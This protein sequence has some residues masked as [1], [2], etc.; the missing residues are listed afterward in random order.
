MIKYQYAFDN[1]EQIIHVNELSRENL[2][3]EAKFKC[4]SC[5]SELIPRLGK[6][7]LKH[8]AH[9]Q[10]N[11]CSGETYLHN[12]AKKLFYQEFQKCL[13]EKIPFKIEL[14]QPR[15]CNRYFDELGITCKL[16]DHL[17]KYDLTKY[18]KE[19]QLEKKDDKFRPDI[20]LKNENKKERLYIEIA[21]THY[22]EEKK[23]NTGFRLIEIKVSNESDLEPIRNHLITINDSNTSFINFKIKEKTG[24][25][26]KK[27]CKINFD[28]FTV[29]KDGRCVIQERSL[30]QIYNI[31]K[32]KDSNI[33]HFEISKDMDD[34]GSKYRTLV[35]K[36]YRIDQIVRNCFICRYHAI[37]ENWDDLRSPIFCKFLKMTGNSNKAV[38]C[39]YFKA[40]N[41]YIE[42]LLSPDE[43]KWGDYG[44][45]L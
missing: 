14:N 26:C 28:L 19:I 22:V 40:E 24:T 41:K 23:I 33:V 35:A 6:I 45:D 3:K 27:E 17:V 18:Y 30:T 21:V 1:H 13:K 8:F 20:I 43:L 42:K 2:S 12:L 9:K 38:E 4:I 16:T 25:L 34:L 15:L 37:N 11:S 5:D 7:R 29:N 44:L 36:Y 32:L 10:E 39:E 31:I